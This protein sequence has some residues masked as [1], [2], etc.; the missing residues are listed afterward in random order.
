MM[1]LA[2]KFSCENFLV[3]HKN[4]TIEVIFLI[5]IPFVCSEF[6]ALIKSFVN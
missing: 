3:G 2:G 1:N 5:R 6:N 4:V